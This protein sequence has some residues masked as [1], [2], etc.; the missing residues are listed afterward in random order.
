MTRNDKSDESNTDAAAVWGVL[1][2]NCPLPL[3]EERVMQRSKDSGRSD[4]NL[5]SLR[6]RFKTF[7][8]ET[9]PV[10]NVLKIIDEKTSSMLKV[11]EI[12][13]QK[14]IEEVWEETQNNMN[15]FIANDVLSAN[16]RLLEAVANG[17]IDSY[18]ALCAE[19]M[20]SDS[21]DNVIEEDL[22][23]M[24][25]QEAEGDKQSRKIDVK[26][27]EM[28]FITGR[29]VSVSYDRTLD[30]GIS[31]RETRI[32]SHQGPKG[33]KLVHFYRDGAR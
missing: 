28:I 26:C 9:V 31:F 13:G 19:E 2:Y 14:S 8:S 24:K 27:A 6:R 32:W 12:E 22:F 3:L 11:V 5:E 30:S 23:V 4:D 25:E 7:Q 20:F 29:K 17:D 1:S 10:V 15:S 16:M 33:W 21:Q 18:R